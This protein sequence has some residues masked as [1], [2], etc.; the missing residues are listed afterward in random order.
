MFQYVGVWYYLE[1]I[2]FPLDVILQTALI[3][4]RRTT[5]LRSIP[6]YTLYIL[7][8][9]V[10][11][12]AYIMVGRAVF[13]KGIPVG[14]TTCPE[15][16]VLSPLPE[17]EKEMVLALCGSGV[18]R[19]S[20]DSKVTYFNDG[21]TYFDSLLGEL[22]SAKTS[23]CI[24]CYLIRS[25]EFSKRFISLLADKAR[26]GVKVRIVFDDFGYDGKDLTYVRKLRTAGAECGIFHNMT[27]NMFSPLKNYRNHRKLTVIDGRT[28][29]VGGYN[30]GEEYISGGR[31]GN[32]NDSAIRIDGPQSQELLGSFSEIWKYVTH[33]D[34]SGDYTLF[35]TVPSEGN[36]PM[37]T[38]SGNPI[39]PWENPFLAQMTQMFKNAKEHIIIE[40]PY[41]NFPKEVLRILKEKCEKGLRLDVVIPAFEDHPAVYWCNRWVAYHLINSGA[42][43]FEYT[44]GF[45]HGKV[46]VCDGS[47]CSVG[48]A[49]YD[50]RSVTLNFECNALILSKEFAE[51]VESSVNQAVEHS[52]EYTAEMFESRTPWQRFRT[53][54]SLLFASQI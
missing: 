19:F 3:A 46:S 33:E 17:T 43:V 44:G 51:G 1:F 35:T 26:E 13:P 21:K 34:I 53:A 41:L 6:W 15:N 8:P 11:F 32:W 31:F 5:V 9:I 36:V 4:Y 18:G 7:A 10:G 25:D 23:I 28:S 48:S 40:T 14:K 54:L 29:F 37:M 16:S 52:T 38:V 49:N 20:A 47:Y 27:R 39:T 12:G 2:F 30:I 45:L 22:A 24:E 42:R 50:M